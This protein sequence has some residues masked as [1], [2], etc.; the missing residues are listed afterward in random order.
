MSVLKILEEIGA[1]TK[2]THKLETLTRHKDNSVFMRVV[3]LALDPYINF[4]IKKIPDYTFRSLENENDSHKTL[5]WALDELSKLSSREL[6]GNA[7]IEHLSSIL[8]ELDSDDAIVVERIIGKDLRCGMADGIVNAVVEGFIPTYP[9]LLAR[10]YDE[11]NIKNIVYPAISQKKGDGLRLNAHVVSGK[12]TLC[13]RSGREIDILGKM[14]A[15]FSALGLAYGKDCVFDGEMIVVD[16]NENILPRKISN[17]ILNKAI[18]GTISEKE[19]D[20]VRVMLWDVIPLTEFKSGISSETYDI[21]FDKVSSIVNNNKTDSKLSWIIE[22][23]EVRS[24]EEA[25]EHF[26]E[27]LSQGEEGTLLKNKHS[28]WEDTRSKHLVK[29]KSEKECD[30]SIVGYNPGEGKFSGMVGSLICE[31]SDGKVNVAISGFSDKLRQEITNNI[32]LLIGKVVEITYNERISS[33]Q[34]NRI[35]VDSLFL[36]RFSRFREDKDV[37]NSSDEIK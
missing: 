36:P 2:R 13:G 26:E 7:G 15:H 9:C 17:G 3:K 31:S 22:T 30:L 12:V 1:D 21:R 5:D 20:L 32:D 8:S 11:K 10:P 35:G 24:L 6:T 4:Y 14:D 27:M 34:A 33:D 23:K 16:Q 28:L 25:I 37:A 18:K 19:A 29:F